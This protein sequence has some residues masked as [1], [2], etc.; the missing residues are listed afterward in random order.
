[1]DLLL[2]KLRNTK[3]KNREI[4]TTLV[5]HLFEYKIVTTIRDQNEADLQ[6][7]F[8]EVCECNHG[9][10]D[11]LRNLILQIRQRLR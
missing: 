2:D 10:P 11:D 5:R 9:L 8:C 3:S 4:L 7:A 6:V 1:M